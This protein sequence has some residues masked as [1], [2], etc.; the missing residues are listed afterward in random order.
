MRDPASESVALNVAR[1]FTISL[2]T[3]ADREEIY[4]ARHDVYGQ[5][6]GQHPTN[7]RGRLV[8]E[9]DDRNAYLVGRV[10][11]ELAGFVSITPAGSPSFSIDKYFSRASLPFSFG[12]GTHEVRLLTV[13]EPFRGSALAS[14]LMYAAF[15]WIQAQGGTH[16]A[17]IGRRDV[18]DLYLR[19]GLVPVGLDT[20]AGAVTYDLLHAE[21]A[22][23]ARRAND[24]D[25]VLRRLEQRADWS[26]PFAF[27]QP[28]PCFH[29]GALFEVLGPGVDAL[30]RASDVVNADVLD[31]WFPPSPGVLRALSEN[32]PWLLRTSPPTGCE[33]LAEHVAAVRGVRPAN[34]LPGAGSSDLIFRALPH[35]LTKHSRALI[36]DPTYG[37]YAHVL[38]R[39]VGCRVDRLRLH[40][41]RDY[42]VDLEALAEALGRGYD[43]IMLV[44][45][46]SPTGQHIHR[47]DLE[48]VLGG[49]PSATRI[50]IDETYVEYT[51]QGQSL[52]PFA[53][54][55]ENVI[56]C[57]SMS[58]VYGLSGARVAYLCA[59][60]H[61]LESLRSITPPW[62]VNLPA[63]VAA[64]HALDDPV[65]Y[66]R[67]HV[68][69]AEARERLRV[70]V[71]ALGLDVVPSTANFI[72]CHLPESGPTAADVVARCRAENVLIRDAGQMGA[73][74]GARAI[75]IAVKSP[76]DNQRIVGALARAVT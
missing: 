14:L 60:A 48:A 12:A 68:E 29:G 13:V 58:K 55:S 1:R 64:V 36:L 22:H 25:G 75:R 44:N 7:A 53:A 34:I 74:L 47:S 43:L 51:G 72:L 46:N 9:L 31:A 17:A 69:T 6:L 56:V 11:N 24:H 40:R 67:R 35:W 62:A 8:D 26:L 37:E 65:Y 66:A 54:R 23:L 76:P 38:E 21:V 27:F 30:S 70:E 10:G 59:A 61:Q 39:V 73:S 57:K 71:S 20:Q 50:W 32:L 3:A 4:Q 52:E 28:V 49:V 45:P 5:E 16:V 41:A 2:A 33:L 19:A 42:R 15:R 18:L 63:Q